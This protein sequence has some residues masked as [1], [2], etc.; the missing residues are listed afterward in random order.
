MMFFASLKMMLLHFVP[1]VMRCLPKNVAKPRIIKRS[2]HHWAKPNI[3]CRR[4][5]SFKKRTFVGRQRCVFCC[6][7]RDNIFFH[8]KYLHESNYCLSVSLLYHTFTNKSRRKPCISSETCCGR[9]LVKYSAPAEC[10]IIS[11]GNCEVLLLRRNVK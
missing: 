8:I 6:L 1:R 5:T 4:Q 7:K 2:C 9:F 3:I 10:E 11:F